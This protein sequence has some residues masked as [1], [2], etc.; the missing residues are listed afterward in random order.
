M[1]DYMMKSKIV[2]VYNIL[3]INYL[4]LFGSLVLMGIKIEGKK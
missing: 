4:T 2:M 3:L 1:N